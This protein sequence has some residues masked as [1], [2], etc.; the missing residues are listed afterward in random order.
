MAVDPSAADDR[1]DRSPRRS[2][3]R[4][5]TSGLV[6]ALLL[7]IAVQILRARDELAAVQHLSVRV[8]AGGCALQLAS[9]IFLN[10]SFLLPLRRC[11][12]G[13]GFWELYLVRTGGMFAGS[14]VPVAGG[15][16]V[17]L[18][19]LKSRGLTYV[20]FAWTTLVSNLLALAAAGVMA[21]GATAMLWR[22]GHQAP[23]PIVV[24]TVAL[25][26]VSAGA[27]AGLMF[28]P[29]LARCRPFRRWPWL[30]DATEAMNRPLAAGVFGLSLARHAAN[31]VTFG[32][33]YQALARGSGDF[34][35]GGVVYALTSPVRMVNVTPGNLGVT[36]WFVA[37]AG[38]ALAFDLAIGLVV[39]LLFRALGLAAQALGAVFGMV[40]IAAASRRPA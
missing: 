10:G 34:L 3:R 27:V 31:F 32:W 36:E 12:S 38:Q 29:R 13:L 7:A 24:A 6:A 14:L 20:D 37:L 16:A 17:R 25:L 40:W 21:A 39:A 5:L 15:L 30:V 23:T 4:W 2:A 8:L 11:V 22:A 18:A 33:L 19:Y 9:Q 1:E 35:A 26:I 28:A